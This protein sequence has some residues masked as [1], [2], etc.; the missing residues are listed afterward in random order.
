MS[1]RVSDVNFLAQTVKVNGRTA[2]F[3]DTAASAL[4]KYIIRR[5][6]LFPNS[7]LLFVNAAGAR[8]SRQKYYFRLKR[9]A[10][11]VGIDEDKATPQALRNSLAVHLLDDGA[12]MKSVQNILR[13]KQSWHI[14]RYV[15]I[16]PRFITG[17]KG[18][19][20]A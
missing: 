5:N 3:G 9:Y 11:K 17:V 6:E 15:D 1:L 4:H 16:T 8:L 20:I 7:D 2:F 19:V 14:F 10:L 13:Y 18:L 12:D